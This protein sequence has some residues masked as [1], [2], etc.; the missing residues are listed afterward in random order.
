MKDY[1]EKLKELREDNDITQKTIADL[2]GI[3][4][5]TYSQYETKKRKMPIEEFRKLCIYYK[6]S[7]DDL[8]GLT[9]IHA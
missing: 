1:I 6:V 3:Q 2:L 5:N 9:N 7:A 4:Q 8:L